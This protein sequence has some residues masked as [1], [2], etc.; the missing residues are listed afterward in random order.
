MKTNLKEINKA[1]FNSTDQA[2]IEKL[3]F[4][5]RYI[6]AKNH[7]EVDACRDT[8]IAQRVAKKYSLDKQIEILL[9]GD[10]GEIALLK[11]YRSQMAT[12]VDQLI[13]EFETTI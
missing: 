12:E 5:K 4:K 13:V 1:I 7:N 8:E 9:N 6:I 3:S 10:V 2:A 11:A